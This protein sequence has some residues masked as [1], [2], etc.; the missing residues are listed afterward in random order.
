M[1]IS[2]K[3][4][5]RGRQSYKQILRGGLPFTISFKVSS[6]RNLH[7]SILFQLGYRY[8]WDNIKQIGNLIPNMML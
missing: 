4:Q 2:R 7:A 3:Q 6:K 5:L 1:K 8:L